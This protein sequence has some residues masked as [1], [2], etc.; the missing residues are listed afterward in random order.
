[1]STHSLKNIDYIK[2]LIQSTNTDFDIIA[3]SG[4]R[5]VKNK[6]PPIDISVPNYSYKFN[7]TEANAGS[8]MIYKRNHLSYITRNDLKIYKSR[9]NIY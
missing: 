3:V 2:H 6:L 8:T 4:S 7:P 1:M 9:I 5:L